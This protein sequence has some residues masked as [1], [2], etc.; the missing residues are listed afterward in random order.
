METFAGG[1]WSTENRQR[2]YLA[3]QFPEYGWGATGTP[4][5]FPNTQPV[6][7]R[8]ARFEELDAGFFFFSQTP[9]EPYSDSWKG[10]FSS[11]S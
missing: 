11:L 1:P 7:Y 9:D 8:L 10:R 3:T 5:G 4:P 6:M 2:E